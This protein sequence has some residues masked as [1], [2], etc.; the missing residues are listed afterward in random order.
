MKLNI[1]WNRWNINIWPMI[2]SSLE[3]FFRKNIHTKIFH[4]LLQSTIEFTRVFFLSVAFSVI[5]DSFCCSQSKTINECLTMIALWSILR[6]VTSR[7][8]I[9][10]WSLFEREHQS[11][12]WMSTNFTIPTDLDFVVLSHTKHIRFNVMYNGFVCQF[13][14]ATHLLLLFCIR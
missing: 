8:A 5:M 4:Y 6:F 13:I 3:T 9:D 14:L 12:I 11:I 1:I 2:E 10:R 7:L